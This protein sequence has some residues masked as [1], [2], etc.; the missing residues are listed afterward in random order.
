[1][2]KRL[3][4]YSHY[5]KDNKKLDKKIK[6]VKKSNDEE[7][8]SIIEGRNAVIELLKS[9]REINKVLIAKGERQGSINEIISLCKDKGIVFQIARGSYC[10]EWCKCRTKKA[11]HCF[12]SSKEF[13][14]C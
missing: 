1:M 11:I 13:Y 5:N 14:R 2:S 10:I 12:Q 7:F 9:Q 8:S 4:T 6:E 3:D